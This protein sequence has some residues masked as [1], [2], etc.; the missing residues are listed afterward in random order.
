M[1]PT[2]IRLKRSTKQMLVYLSRN[3]GMYQGAVIELALKRLYESDD[4]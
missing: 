4:V 3:M 2:S 1:K